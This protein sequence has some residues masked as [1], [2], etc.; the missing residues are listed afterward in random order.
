MFYVYVLQNEISKELYYG[1]TNSL[2]RRIQEHNKDR[3]CKLVYYEAFLSE[4][5]A[6]RREKKLKQ[7]GQSR[8]HLKK[9]ITESLRT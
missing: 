5:D 2:D 3:K 7:Y 6:Y 8:N 1:F 9:R 4:L